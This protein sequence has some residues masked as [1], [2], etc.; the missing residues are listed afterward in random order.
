MSAKRFPTGHMVRLINVAGLSPKTAAVYRLV[1]PLPPRDGSSQYRLRNEEFGQE[2]DLEPV[3]FCGAYRPG[4]H[5][6][7][8][9]RT[10]FC[11]DRMQQEA[12]ATPF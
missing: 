12:S 9:L 3:C 2:R 11:G 4:R 5:G 10:D 1:A 8:V 7:H 6:T